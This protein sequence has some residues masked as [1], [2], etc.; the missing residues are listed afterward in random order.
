MQ[1]TVYVLTN[2][3]MPGLCKVGITA[4]HVETR[5]KQLFTSGGPV[6]FECQFAVRVPNAA[7]VEKPLHHAFGDH[8]VNATREFFR[9]DQERVK[10]ALLLAGGEIVTPKHD[11]ADTAED[12]K[13]LNDAK[14][15]QP[16]FAFSMIGLKPG[17]ELASTFSEQE[18]CTVH[19]DRKVMFRG[20][21]QSLSA[22]ALVVAHEQGYA[23]SVIQ[24]P[25]Y[26]MSEGKTLNELRLEKQETA[27]EED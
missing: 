26:W 14:Q 9:I 19:S 5:M 23:W 22:A 20:A 15:R 11:V 21:V 8:R 13:A 2:P 25:Q 16:A 24:G 1:G 7:S 6:P 4:G 17:D 18:T 3:L 12:I 27:D 10:S